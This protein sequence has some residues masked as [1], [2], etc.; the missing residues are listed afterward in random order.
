MRSIEDYELRDKCVV[1]SLDSLRKFAS[2]T[3]KYL[4]PAALDGSQGLVRVSSDQTMAIVDGTATLSSR[5]VIFGPGTLSN[6]AEWELKGL[7]QRVHR[8]AELH[9]VANV[10]R[11]WGAYRWG[12][13]GAFYVWGG[14]GRRAYVEIG[15]EQSQDVFV[16]L[17][18]EATIRVQD[19]K[20]DSRP[21]F[22]AVRDFVAAIEAGLAV[23][24][25]SPTS[26][27]DSLDRALSLGSLRAEL[28]EASTYSEWLPVIT[29]SQRDF[30]ERPIERSIKLR[31]AAG[32]G[33]TLA[34]KLKAIR[35]IYAA[36]D[37]DRSI[38]LLFA[39]HGWA[40]A[41]D[42]QDSV[43]KLDE[44]KSASGC[45]DIAP[46]LS[47]ALQHTGYSTNSLVLD[48]DSHDGKLKAF[49]TIH[50]ALAD[51]IRL[52]WP[53][54]GPGASPQIQRRVH[55]AVARSPGAD[56]FVVEL[57]DEFA[58]VLGAHGI[59]RGPDAESKYLNLPRAAWMLPLGSKNDKTFVY[60][61]YQKFLEALAR[62][63]SLS[64]DQVI[65]D[66]VATLSGFG[67][68]L[69]RLTDGYDAIFV[70]EMHLF[71]LQ[72]RMLIN[73]LS[74]Q[75]DSYPRVVMAL[76]PR[77]S[78]SV[79]F[80]VESASQPSL[81]QDVDDVCLRNVY[82]FGESI[83][84]LV[85][86]LQEQ[87]PTQELGKDW[88]LEQSAAGGKKAGD[89]PRLYWD[90]SAKQSFT[91]AVARAREISRSRRVA[92]LCLHA[93]ELDA[94]IQECES[95]GFSVVPVKGRSDQNELRYAKRTPVVSAAEYVAGLQFD[96]V[97][98][99]GVPQE[100]AA[101]TVSPYL[102][103]LL[104]T[105]LYLAVTRARDMVDLHFPVE[106]TTMQK[107]LRLAVDGGIVK[108][109]QNKN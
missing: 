65:N 39:T 61:V 11:E 42:I 104:L 35:E 5:R 45:L 41:Y 73:H 78:A 108:V 91:N 60:R 74:N 97:V 55:A 96:A 98:V 53:A 72:E 29:D 10:P 26:S 40:A 8:V 27:S 85:R 31:G 3:A 46:L 106:S 23:I 52:N 103:R 58:S 57:M 69:E 7:L 100:V 84:A 101:G 83:L 92:L 36:Q 13:R 89:I 81:S 70:D 14:S 44:R 47:I 37:A 6:A 4:R 82:R 56:T 24:R 75:P 109:V 50:E 105:M 34:M 93:S 54:L 62:Q 17:V 33:K 28:D 63:K 102:D 15:P 71:S 12:N 99:C 21:Y 16:R 66:C 43:D 38:R 19:I 107:L 32:T 67:W 22:V 88:V 25:R 1:F 90:A 64:W 68:N 59:V 51:A 87:F 2:D 48:N 77:Q 30:L 18:S 94:L 20:C 86:H 9:S 49:K 95:A 80:G 79:L 76:D